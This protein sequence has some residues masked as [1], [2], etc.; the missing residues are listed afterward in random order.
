VIERALYFNIADIL[1]ASAQ[2]NF[3]LFW[4]EEKTLTKKE[5]I[6]KC[7]VDQQQHFAA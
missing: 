4:I 2:Q 3:V 7:N 6:T 5:E 1:V